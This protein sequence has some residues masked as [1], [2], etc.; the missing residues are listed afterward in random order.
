MASRVRAKLIRQVA[1]RRTGSEHPENVV[2]NTP[3]IYAEDA[4]RFGRQDRLIRRWWEQSSRGRA[5]KGSN[6]RQ[7]QCQLPLSRVPAETA[8]FF[9]ANVLGYAIGV[10]DVL[11]T[12]SHAGHAIR[13]RKAPNQ[14]ETSASSFFAGA[15][16]VIG[17]ARKR[18]CMQHDHELAGASGKRRRRRR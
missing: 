18:E 15:F 11:Q 2:Q 12:R 13:T 14:Y 3:V 5:T 6:R 9:P 1:P 10:E 4:A 16:F 17:N 7:C 8:S